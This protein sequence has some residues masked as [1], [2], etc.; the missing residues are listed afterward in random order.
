ML[1]GSLDPHT[2]GAGLRNMFTVRRCTR[3]N[4]KLENAPL[5][6]FFDISG[7]DACLHISTASSEQDIVGV[8]VHRKHGRPDGFLQQ[9]RDPPIVLRVK[10]ADSNGTG[11]RQYKLGLKK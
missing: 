10:R 8:P 5:I 7:E 3:R 11:E 1:N 6:H 2:V 4:N 9:F